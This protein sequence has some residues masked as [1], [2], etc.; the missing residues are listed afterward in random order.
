MTSPADFK[1]RAFISYSHADTRETRW[2]HRQLEGFKIDRDLVGRAT[3]SGPIPHTLRPIFRDRDDFTAGHTLS[4]Q[5]LAALDASAALVVMCSPASAKSQYVNEEIRLFKSR[6][7]GRPVIPVIVAGRPGNGDAECFPP[8]LRFQLG[9]DGTITPSPAEVLAADIREDGDGRALAVAKV[10]ARLLNLNTDDIFRRAERER[11]RRSR[12]WIAG[13]SAVAVSLAGLAVWAEVN[14]REAVAQRKEAVRNFALAKGA[15]DSLVVDIAQGLRNVEGM[16]SE[17]VAKILGTARSTIDKLAEA[18]P[19][20]VELQSSRMAM[21]YA[22]GE[23]LTVQSD[24]PNAL[25]NYRTALAI[26]ERLAKSNPGNSELQRVVA[27]SH[28]KI[29]DVLRLQG[30]LP[31]AMDSFQAVLAITEALARSNSGSQMDQSNLS[32]AYQDIGNVLAERSDLSGALERHLAA[33]AIAEKLANADPGNIDLQRWLS[34]A[35]VK[36]PWAPRT[37]P[38]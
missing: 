15:A 27:A 25:E 4:D 12:N 3:P 19:G 18:A 26:A 31:A 6:H 34:S 23:T 28:H 29:G 11:R 2:L 22:F 17:T 5:T 10:V 24:L 20:N 37:L 32:I 35:A 36:L 16:R 30:N 8:A 14:R 33:R 7:P 13:L 1:Y 9:A 21:L 38:M